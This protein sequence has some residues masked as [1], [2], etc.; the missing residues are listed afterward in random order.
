MKGTKVMDWIS[1][2]LCEIAEDV[3]DDPTLEDNE[4]I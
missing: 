3:K 4:T 1:Y 2:M